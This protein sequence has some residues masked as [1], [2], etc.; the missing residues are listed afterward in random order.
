MRLEND[1]IH[2]F[3]TIKSRQIN[4][5]AFIEKVLPAAPS[6]ADRMH[7]GQGGNDE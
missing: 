2:H 1:R 5:L 3:P 4:A 7:S 6:R